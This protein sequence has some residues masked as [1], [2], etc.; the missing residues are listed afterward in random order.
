M[1][2]SI[3]VGMLLWR[4]PS[5]YEYTLVREILALCA[6]HMRY[7]EQSL[8][9]ALLEEDGDV[10]LEVMNKASVQE[11]LSSVRGTIHEWLE[12]ETTA[13]WTDWAKHGER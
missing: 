10:G 5:P 2:S 6:K 1:T 12:G 3:D 8:V 9:Y 4:P 11:L 13:H 7:D